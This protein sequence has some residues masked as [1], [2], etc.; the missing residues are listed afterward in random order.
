MRMPNVIAG[1][2]HCNERCPQFDG[3]RCRESALRVRHGDSCVPAVA[4]MS[5]TIATLKAA[6]VEACAFA[7]CDSP[8]GLD[9]H[10]RIA[11]LRQLAEAAR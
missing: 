4:D 1:V 9:S 7:S 5:K 6:L 3:K 8:L 2:P 11:E 10:L